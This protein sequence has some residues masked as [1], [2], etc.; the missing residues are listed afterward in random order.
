[1]TSAIK[2]TGK[3]QIWAVDD[4]N[5]ITYVSG[6]RPNLKSIL[7]YNPF[8]PVAHWAGKDRD[9]VI[10]AN[11]KFDK[12][13]LRERANAKACFWRLSRAKASERLLSLK[14]KH[15]SLMREIKKA[16]SRKNERSN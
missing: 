15:L 1:M 13:T 10:R 16:R 14:I 9:A 5:E 6:N 2:M 12:E 4:G 11:K 3:L 7:I 8:R